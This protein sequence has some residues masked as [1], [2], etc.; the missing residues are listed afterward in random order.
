M[1]GLRDLHVRLSHASSPR[2]EEEKLLE[3]LKIVKILK[4]FDVYIAWHG[5]L[6][7]GDAPFRLIRPAQSDDES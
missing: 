7:F 3:P 2:I 6:T 1:H 4:H 5:D